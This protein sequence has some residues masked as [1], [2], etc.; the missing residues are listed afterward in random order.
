MS[1]FDKHSFYF[2]YFQKQELFHITLLMSHKSIFLSPLSE[3]SPI[4]RPQALQPFRSLSVN[5]SVLQQDMCCE[6]GEQFYF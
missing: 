2:F 4:C 3:P 5:M 1:Y 6:F